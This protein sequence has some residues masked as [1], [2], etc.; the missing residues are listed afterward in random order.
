MVLA[1]IGLLCVLAPWR[2][3][4]R[5]ALW[6]PDSIPD[7]QGHQVAAM[8]DEA[9]K[10]G[11]KWGEKDPAF[12]PEKHRMPYLE[13]FEA[14]TNANGG[15]M[16][17][18]S[19]GSY[20]Y[21]CDL[22]LVKA[23]KERFTGL[24][25]R[26]VN[27][28]YRTPRPRRG[29]PIYQSAWEDGQRAIRLIRSQASVRGIDPEKI[30]IIGMSAGGHLV[31]MLATSSLRRAYPR[32][33]E[34]DDLPCHVNLAIANAPA[35]NTETSADGSARPQ[36]GT[37]LTD[38]K[39]NP[40]FDFDARTC[41]ISFHHGGN[42][43]Y[44]PNGSTL[45]YREMH[46]RGIPAELHLY[47]DRGHGAWGLDRAVEF[48]R[49]MNFDGRLGEEENCRRFTG[50]QTERTEKVL[51]WPWESLP[52]RQDCQTNA[53]FLTWYF[54]KVCR[55]RAIQVVLPG[56]AYQSCNVSGE[57]LPIVEY[58]NGKGMAVVV[59]NYRCPRPLG[60]E[61]H[62]TAWQD[63]QRAIRIVRSQA[64]SRGLDPE[65]IGVMGFS[66]GGHLTLLCAVNSTKAAYAPVDEVDGVS[67]GV[68]WACPVYPA[69]VLTDGPN[70]PNSN[71][72]C[73]GHDAIV[74]ELA[75][76]AAT[77]P[78][79]FLHGDADGYS[80][81]G[82]VRCW[83]KLRALGIQCDLHTL[84]T[85]GHCFQFKAAPDTG[86]WTWLD[87]I[88]DF[89]TAKGFNPSASTCGQS[90]RSAPSVVGPNETAKWQEAIDAK[91]AAGGGVVSVPAGRHRVAGLALKSNVTLHLDEGCVL[92]GSTNICDYADIRLRY[93]EVPE[94]WQAVVWAEGQTNV[95]VIGKGVIDGNGL[96]FRQGELRV[97]RPR[98]ML[99][100][101][102]ANVRVEDIT[103]R[104]LASWT[105][106]YKECNGVVHRNV[107]VFSHS[108]WNTD[109]VDIEAKNVLVENCRFDTGD[110]GIVLKS[111]NPFFAVEDVV[112]RNCDIGTSCNVFKIG[113]ASHG[114][115]RRIRFENV[116]GHAASGMLPDPADRERCDRWRMEGWPGLES[117]KDP[118]GGIV[119]E[120]VDGACLEDVSFENIDLGR[121]NV[122]IFIR[123]GLRRSRTAFGKP[124]E[125]PFGT[126]LALKNVRIAN[127]KAFG[128]S[129]TASSITG[130]PGLRIDGVTLKEVE[131]SV[132]GSGEAGAKDMTLG[133]VPENVEEYPE[134]NMF[135]NRI[136]PAYGFFVRHAD[137]VRFENV[138]CT[139]RGHERRPEVVTEDV[140]AF[141]RTGRDL[142]KQ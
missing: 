51:L 22:A 107:T 110:D 118:L 102:C 136:L 39:V 73:G 7:F 6:P 23:W 72:G 132:P 59:V 93:A 8:T 128:T 127:V 116:R 67:C 56:G 97:G 134:S 113:T 131:I 38:L 10:S 65:R 48:I 11:G 2:N 66:A 21:C 24:G 62:V 49:Q 30:G 91:S 35:Y 88:W 40:C 124:L 99:F 101:R 117:V 95:A 57:G 139:V 41:P 37:T 58:F 55:T 90:F 18:V 140:N 70:G 64:P 15:C 119:V 9:W 19:G 68:Q 87:R 137:N 43:Q 77:P 135:D 85:R 94:P 100:Y 112:V 130:V 17:L 133:P 83:E 103:M 81:M 52:S 44:T 63:A 32:I 98:G 105:C 123:A 5:V 142:E 125:I 79:C 109:G 138:R 69:Y 27:L 16:V 61:K 82:S 1:A 26:C 106:Y 20:R 115:F 122:P 80:S 53:P 34:T 14:P 47:A 3:G 76:D 60:I 12:G 96:G 29:L 84:A 111:D 121:V 4:E 33:D 36:D 42:D 13:W 114:A 78:M 120:C 89:L 28:V 129:W 141:V 54:P 75:F 71:A 31:T 74:P 46:R 104:S 25:F 86:S 108:N 92:E 45:C 126:G 50:A